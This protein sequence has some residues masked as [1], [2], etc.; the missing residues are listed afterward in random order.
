ML[1]NDFNGEMISFSVDHLLNSIGQ[2]SHHTH[3]H[4]TA[5]AY[6]SIMQM[7]FYFPDL[8]DYSIRKFIFN[9]EHSDESG[10]TFYRQFK[11]YFIHHKCNCQ[12][13]DGRR[14]GAPLLASTIDSISVFSPVAKYNVRCNSVVCAACLCVMM[15]HSI[16]LNGRFDC[17]R[18]FVCLFFIFI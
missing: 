10:F 17:M 12:N 13:D 2:T 11:A 18:T 15:T 4:T 16:Q 8:L 1:E 6:K 9:F 14:I 5:F 3:T 7:R